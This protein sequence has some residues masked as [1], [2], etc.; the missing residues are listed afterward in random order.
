MKE[1]MICSL[2]KLECIDKFCYLGDLIIARG[3]AEEA[4]RSRVRCT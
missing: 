4:S 2:D 1:M 3:E